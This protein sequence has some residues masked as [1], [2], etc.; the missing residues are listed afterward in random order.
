MERE[1]KE[2]F[3]LWH[4]ILRHVALPVCPLA[5]QIF[6]QKRVVR[7]SMKDDDRKTTY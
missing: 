5:V 4:P 2:A 1:R 6:G 3:M 7:Q